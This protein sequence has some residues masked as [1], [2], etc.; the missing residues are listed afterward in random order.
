MPI[1]FITI[2]V[3]GATNTDAHGINASGQI[4][5]I[6]LTAVAHKAFC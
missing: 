4:V 3:A 5:A 1:S 6:T 2:D